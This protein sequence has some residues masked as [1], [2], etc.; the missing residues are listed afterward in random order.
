MNIVMDELAEEILKALNLQQQANG[1]GSG[2]TSSPIGAFFKVI[3]PSLM[4]LE[5]AH[6]QGGPSE[7]GTFQESLKSFVGDSLSSVTC[8]IKSDVLM[9]EKTCEVFVDLPGV[10]KADIDMSVT[11]ASD[12]KHILGI[13]VVRRP[14]ID[15]AEYLTREIKTGRLEKRITL[16]SNIDVSSIQA[17]YE[18]GVLHVK[19][20][21]LDPLAKKTHKILIG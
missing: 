11:Q 17:K 16:P 2:K 12:S 20:N 18:N 21:R 7:K 15:V 13:S 10:S 1:S 9:T 4:D 6:V 14:L 8:P 3:E 19:I 5:K